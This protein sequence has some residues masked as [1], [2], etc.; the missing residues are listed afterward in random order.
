MKMRALLVGTGSWAENHAKAYQVCQEVE[1]AG[2][3][4]VIPAARPRLE[5][6]GA[7][8]GIPV[9]SAG[10]AEAVAELQPDIVD[11]ACNPHFRLEAVRQCLAPCV[12]LINLEKPLALTPEDGYAIESLCKTHGKLATVGH[13]K[14]WLPAWAKAKTLIDQGALG[15]IRFYRGTCYGNLLEQGTHLV[16]MILHFH[17]YRPVRWVMGQVADLQ[18][19]D[20]PGAPAP[21]AA[22]AIVCFDDKVRAY[23]TLGTVGEP[24]PS[25]TSFW[26]HW[27]VEAYGTQG[28]LRNAL[29]QTLEVTT[30]AEG[31]TRSEESSWDKGW[32]TALAAHLDAAARYAREP[33]IGHI[34]CLEHSMQSF[35]VVMAIYASA[36]GA[37]RVDLP[38]RFDNRVL[39]RLK[40][41]RT[42]P[43]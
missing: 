36:A 28:H 37:G 25:E 17:A 12:R 16:D 3:V 21:D 32:L 40:A 15:T 41:R 34:S 19:F 39:E 13:Q 26:L 42:P 33:Q 10:L 2:I 24:L 43:V 38:Q 29:N 18:G 9:R 35:A 27:G 4:D 14:K 6:V 5:A 8:Y 31:K 1:L 20:K 30:Y 11:I 22:T 23:L 7:R